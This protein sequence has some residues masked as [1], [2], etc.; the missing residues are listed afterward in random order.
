MHIVMERGTK[1]VGKMKDRIRGKQY[2]LRGR[3]REDVKGR[4][5]KID[6]ERRRERKRDKKRGRERRREEERGGK[7][8]REDF[9]FN[10]F[11]N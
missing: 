10:I 6:E 3:E 1:R 7:R 8:K 9:N 5:R 4:E 11:Q 2:K